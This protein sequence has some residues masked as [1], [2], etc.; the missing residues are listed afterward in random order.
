MNVSQIGVM[1]RRLH[2]GNVA[3]CITENCFT[4][5]FINNDIL[6]FAGGGQALFDGFSL[7]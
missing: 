6:P 2:V 5:I 1:L 4:I 3:Q 7:P